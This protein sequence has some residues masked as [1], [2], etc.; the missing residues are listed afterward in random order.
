[1]DRDMVRVENLEF[2]KGLANSIIVEKLDGSRIMLPTS[3]IE[4]DIEAERGDVIAVEMP[5]WLARD[6]WLTSDT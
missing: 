4:Y 1:M 3:E 5:E 6:R 2:V